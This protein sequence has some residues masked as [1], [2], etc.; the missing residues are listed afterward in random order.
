M[1]AKVRAALALLGVSATLFLAASPAQ[2]APANFTR[3]SNAALNWAESHAEGHPYIW[4]GTGPYGYDC[5]GLVV[6]AF[7]REGISLPHNT[8][9]MIES[10]KLIRVYSP[11]RGDLAFWGDPRWPSHVEFVTKW[12]HT[13]FGAQEP[14]TV[15]YWHHW[16]GWWAPS[17]FWRVE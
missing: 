10:G 13:S 5:S 17:S 9:A 15:V 12:Y 16:N 1:G 2:A 4:A 8:V 11:Q 3:I 7:A 6:A 14:G